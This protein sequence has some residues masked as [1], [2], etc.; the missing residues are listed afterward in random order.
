MRHSFH[1]TL[2]VVQWWVPSHDKLAR[3]G[4]VAPPCGEIAARALNARVDRAAREFFGQGFAQ[5][6][7]HADVC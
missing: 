1:D 5:K 4:W 3:S 6:S 7:V 2:E